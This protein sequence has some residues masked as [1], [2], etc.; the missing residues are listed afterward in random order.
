MTANDDAVTSQLH[1]SEHEECRSTDTGISDFDLY[2]TSCYFWFF[3]F[4]I[5]Y[6]FICNYYCCFHNIYYSFREEEI[7]RVRA[8]P[9][10]TPP[11]F[12]SIKVFQTSITF[13]LPKFIISL[14]HHMCQRLI[15]F[16]ISLISLIINF[17][18][19]RIW[20]MT[21]CFFDSK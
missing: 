9:P 18:I 17:F 14:C 10:S 15:K 4:L 11:A 16:K 6:I 8:P 20:F 3:N 19:L 5:L 7:P 1:D 21:A 2:G 13:N 12:L